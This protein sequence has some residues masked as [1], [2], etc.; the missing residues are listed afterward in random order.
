MCDPVHVLPYVSNAGQVFL[1]S[2]ISTIF[3]NLRWFAFLSIEPENTGSPQPVDPPDSPGQSCEERWPVESEKETIT[4]CKAQRLL[5]LARAFEMLFLWSFFLGRLAIGVPTSVIWWLRDAPQLSRPVVAVY[6]TAGLLWHVM[7]FFWLGKA[8]ICPR[9][10]LANLAGVNVNRKETA[11][12]VKLS[13]SVGATPCTDEMACEVSVSDALDAEVQIWFRESKESITR[14]SANPRFVE[15]FGVQKKTSAKPVKL[16]KLEVESHATPVLSTSQPAPKLDT[17]YISYIH[18]VWYDFSDFKHPGGPV[19]LSLA[20]HRDATALFEA[21]HPFTSRSKLRAVLHKYEIPRGSERERALEQSGVVVETGPDPYEWDHASVSGRVPENKEVVDQFELE[22]K[23]MARQYFV[24]EAK[25]RGVS[26]QQATKA[27]PLR[28]CQVVVLAAAYLA[29]VPSMLRGEWWTLVVSPFLAWVWLANMYHDA[30]H[31]SLSTRWWVNAVLPH[32]TPWL[33]SPL[34]WYHQHVVGHHAYPNIGRKDPDLAHAP[35]LLRHHDTI[36]WRATHRG[37][38]STSRTMF[39][40]VVATFGMQV[41]SDFR[42]LMQGTYNRVVPMQR[43]GKARLFLHFVG[44]TLFFFV[45]YVWPFLVFVSWREDAER[46]WRRAVLFS[47]VPQMIFSL[48][49][50]ACSQVNHLTPS[51]THGASK[52]YFR[53]QVQTAQD[54]M[55][56]SSLAY[57]LSGGLNMQIEHHLFPCVCHCHLRALQPMVAAL[58][59]KHGVG[60][61]TATSWLVA[62]RQHCEHMKQMSENPDQAE[63]DDGHDPYEGADPTLYVWAGLAALGVAV[64]MC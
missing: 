31:F 59:K 16:L 17:R 63:D 62:Y 64:V 1:L 35:Q 20:L 54:F 37:Q 50:M 21:H 32:F 13:M 30:C 11:T 52:N 3:A 44:R 40:W 58:C 15:E 14:I 43:I 24:R 46:D 6:T 26:F 28:W 23:D 61:H 25:R 7:N 39:I 10:R 18:G 5:S 49:F 57:W 4:A 47:F 56:H 27:T 19:A 9:S 55:V 33:S 53:H 2:E 29:T 45:T 41:L 60:Y 38:D 34:T 48:L 12:T 36:R 42:M 8:L 51:T 22:L